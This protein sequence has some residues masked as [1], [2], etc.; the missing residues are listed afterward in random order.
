VQIRTADAAVRDLNVDIIFLPL[1]GLKLL[2]LHL[3]DRV[4]VETEPSLELVIGARHVGGW[5]GDQLVCKMGMKSWGKLYER[6][7]CEI[8]RSGDTLAHKELLR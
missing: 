2:P 4:L 3:A 8:F 5:V 7:R 1:L 6:A